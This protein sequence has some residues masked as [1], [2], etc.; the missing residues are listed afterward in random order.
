MAREASQ[1]IVSSVADSQSGRGGIVHVRGAAGARGS[2]YQLWSEVSLRSQSSCA[3]GRGGVPVT[4]LKGFVTISS[5]FSLSD[6]I[7]GGLGEWRGV[8]WR[9][10]LVADVLSSVKLAMG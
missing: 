9:Q 2:S 3:G 10:L 6:I 5:P 8:V 1:H 7:A 4:N